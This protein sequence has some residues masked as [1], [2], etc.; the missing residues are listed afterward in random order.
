MVLMLEFKMRRSVYIYSLNAST[1]RLT[2]DR[3]KG[4]VTSRKKESHAACVT[5]SS[6]GSARLTS[7]KKEKKCDRSKPRMSER[8]CSL[9]LGALAQYVFT[10]FTLL[11]SSLE[12][13]HQTAQASFRFHHLIIKSL[14]T[15]AIVIRDCDGKLEKATP[16]IPIEHLPD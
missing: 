15:V 11:H 5:G 9:Q 16:L 2:L 4:S 3:L 13:T 12:Q 7:R 6:E 10:F 8:I 1:C 14:H